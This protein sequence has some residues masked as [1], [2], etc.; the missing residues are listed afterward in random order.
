[1]T[2]EKKTGIMGN[3]KGRVIAPEG[4]E[5][6]HRSQWYP[7]KHP[8][9]SQV[10]YLLHPK[11]VSLMT[12]GL[13]RKI[14]R[15]SDY[16]G[17]DFAP[18]EITQV[19]NKYRLAQV[20]ACGLKAAVATYSQHWQGMY[21]DWSLNSQIEEACSKMDT[22]TASER[23]V[24]NAFATV[25]LFNTGYKGVFMDMLRY[26]RRPVPP[27][28][29]SLENID[30]GTFECNLKSAIGAVLGGHVGVNVIKHT[31]SQELIK[32]RNKPG[33][34][35]LK[36]RA[37]VE[38]MDPQGRITCILQ[39]GFKKAQDRLVFDQEMM[40][41]AAAKIIERKSERRNMDF[42]KKV[43]VPVMGNFYAAFNHELNLTGM[44]NVIRVITVHGDVPEGQSVLERIR[45][46]ISTGIEKCREDLLKAYN[47]NIADGTINMDFQTYKDT[48]DLVVSLG[49]KVL[50]PREDA[51]KMLFVYIDLE[52]LEA[53]GIPID[54]AEQC[55][56]NAIQAGLNSIHLDGTTNIPA[57][58]DLKYG[59]FC[60]TGP[61]HSAELNDSD[62]FLLR[63]WGH[64]FWDILAPDMAP[65]NKMLAV[66]AISAKTEQDAFIAER[67]AM[68]ERKSV[69]EIFWYKTWNHPEGKRLDIPQW[70][71]YAH[72]LNVI[73][74]PGNSI[75]LREKQL[76]EHMPSEHPVTQQLMQH[77]R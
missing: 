42:S 35:L 13:I 29:E 16:Q 67:Q 60:L 32:G 75:P 17:R 10:P 36:E 14:W 23:Y 37:L 44:R 12:N 11:S 7:E 43:P 62:E 1:M 77:I 55:A 63:G 71:S 53:K 25:V 45:G 19:P 34:E 38:G 26:R 39:I 50:K 28:M 6:V 46:T 8:G 41:L 3:S 72:V 66:I 58:Q 33:Y 21:F 70:I 47:D 9:R 64:G 18:F 48:A 2:V 49:L 57:G 5:E 30:M 59:A 27:S 24:K 65:R 4:T 51:H 73:P 61:I 31:L 68:D 15:S 20:L 54:V 52:E 74:I 69:N 22:F 76:P 40:D 56:G